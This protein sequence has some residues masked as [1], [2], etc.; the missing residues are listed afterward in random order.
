[1]IQLFDL[2]HD[3][4]SEGR[5]LF[6][7]ALKEIESSDFKLKANYSNIDLHDYH[8]FTV[9]SSE[10]E[11]LCFSGLQK[12]SLPPGFGR[13]ATRMYLGQNFREDSLKILNQRH[14]DGDKRLSY[15]G[16]L[17]MI[18]HQLKIARALQLAGVFI[19]REY[20]QKVKT[21]IEHM[22]LHNGF[23]APEDRLTALEGIYNVCENHADS[24]G[25]W[26]RIAVLFLDPAWNAE[27]IDQ[28]L[29]KIS[30]NDWQMKFR[31]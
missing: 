31:K 21:F 20:P 29:P 30:L 3:D 9:V 28:I 10:G 14:G 24:I 1:M 7:E 4:S 6:A 23:Q 16:S 25:C 15:P 5:R 26:Q 2:C 27:K 19:S 18:P 12:R 22:N 11:L 17:I 13:M 8:S